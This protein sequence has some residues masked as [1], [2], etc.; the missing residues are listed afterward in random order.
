M[1][2]RDMAT[3]VV[4]EVI[5][6]NCRQNYDSNARDTITFNMNDF[7]HCMQVHRMYI[8]WHNCGLPSTSD[9]DN[10]SST[11][12]RKNDTLISHVDE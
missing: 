8:I 1:T 4:Q 5:F 11:F 6:G 10:I 9:I 12:N 3:G 7:L 2:M